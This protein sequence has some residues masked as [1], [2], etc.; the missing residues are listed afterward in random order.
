MT[1]ERL[2]YMFDFLDGL[3][4]SGKVNMFGARP[5]LSEAFMIG[6]ADAS[7]VLTAWMGTYGEAESAQERAAL[8]DP[9][10]ALVSRLSGGQRWALVD[11][12]REKE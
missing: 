6:S 2:G 8:V 7:L 4:A 11:D 9:N 1:P 5:Y 3:R 12:H 10:F